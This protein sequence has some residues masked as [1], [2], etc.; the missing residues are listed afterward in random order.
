MNPLSDNLPTA[1]AEL[2][3]ASGN[4][5]THITYITSLICFRSLYNI[6]FYA[7]KVLSRT[8]PLY[9]SNPIEKYI[10]VRMLRSEAYSFWTIPKSHT[11]IYG[12][13][14]F[15]ASAPRLWNELPNHIKLTHFVRFFK[16]IYLNWN[17]Y[18]FKPVYYV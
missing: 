14:A 13:K 2:S 18:N 11:A 5:H 4:T 12:E 9:L 10:P 3:C 8:A 16:P 6:L 15:R 17:I 1:S 7:F